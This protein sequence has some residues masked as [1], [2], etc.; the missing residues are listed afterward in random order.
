MIFFL[1]YP[2]I[3]VCSLCSERFC[4]TVYLIG[5]R[6]AVTNGDAKVQQDMKLVNRRLI[7]V[8][9]QVIKVTIWLCLLGGIGADMLRVRMWSL[10]SSNS[11]KQINNRIWKNSRLCVL[12]NSSWIVNIGFQK[13][14]KTESLNESFRPLTQTPKI[15]NTKLIKDRMLDQIFGRVRRLLC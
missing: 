10:G 1:R 7:L 3:P 12:W 4:G 9:Q 15:L 13:A 11:T 8:W 6:K 2:R 14:L 5:E